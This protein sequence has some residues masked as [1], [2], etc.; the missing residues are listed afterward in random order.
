[1]TAPNAPVLFRGRLMLGGG[2]RVVLAV[3]GG[4]DPRRC[5]VCAS[6]RGLRWRRRRTPWIISTS[7]ST[8][9]RDLLIYFKRGCDACNCCQKWVCCLYAVFT[10]ETPRATGGTPR[11]VQ[12]GARCAHRAVFN[13][14]FRAANLGRAYG[15][16]PRYDASHGCSLCRQLHDHGENPVMH[17]E[18]SW[19][20]FWARRPLPSVGEP[21]VG[22][23]QRLLVHSEQ[24]GVRGG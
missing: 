2:R 15:K 6:S 20:A 11:T 1:M 4:E 16:Q 9:D 10:L 8:R 24:A 23:A 22:E 17:T 5:E 7:S 3:S 19:G 13:R 12:A 18:R 14:A 21:V